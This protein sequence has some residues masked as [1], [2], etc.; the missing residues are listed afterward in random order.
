MCRGCVAACFL[1]FF[2]SITTSR[3]WQKHYFPSQ[4][5]L[6]RQSLWVRQLQQ[7]FLFYTWS[8]AEIL[9]VLKGH[10]GLVK[11]VSWDPIGK[12][13]AS[14]VRLELDTSSHFFYALLF[15]ILIASL[16]A[17]VPVWRQEPTGMAHSWL[18]A[19]VRHHGTILRGGHYSCCCVVCSCHLQKDGHR[20][21]HELF[22]C[23]ASL[24]AACQSFLFFLM[25][26]I[27]FMS[28]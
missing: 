4:V 13:I 26:K 12:Y 8:F 27:R 2:F 25:H 19:G 9:A 15:V 14:Q 24:P 11:G 3:L 10:T 22:E 5:N 16:F 7:Y 21:E 1:K 18:A 6:R 20:A 23:E 17:L 28:K